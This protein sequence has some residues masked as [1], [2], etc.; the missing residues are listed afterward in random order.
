MSD[1]IL[2]SDNGTNFVSSEFERF[3]QDNCVEHVC[4]PPGHHQS[5]GQAERVIQ[6]LKFFSHKCGSTVKDVERAVIQFC[7]HQNT[8]PAADGSVAADLVFNRSLRTKLS[9]KSTQLNLP[10][11]RTPVRVRHEG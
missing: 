5:I 1:C 2:V 6:E 8:T 4:S 7:P 3:L 9:I 10:G 11:Q